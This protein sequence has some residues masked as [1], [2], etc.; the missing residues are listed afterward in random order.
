MI[1]AIRIRTTVESE[2]L[3]IPELAA[4]MGRRVEIIVFEEEV[5]PERSATASSAPKKRILGGLQG[6]LQVP[7]DFDEPLPED[8]ARA[9][10]GDE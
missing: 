7:D 6:K 1:N 4:L 10:E 5:E 8:V 2:V 3:R 9:F